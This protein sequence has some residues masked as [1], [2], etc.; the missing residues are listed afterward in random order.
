MPTLEKDLG[1]SHGE[2]GSLF[3]L[4]SLGYFITLLGSGFFSSRLLHR[5]TIILS[6]TAV[7]IALLGIAVSNSL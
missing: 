3:L 1:M 6:A 5:K 7:G 2:A 4:I